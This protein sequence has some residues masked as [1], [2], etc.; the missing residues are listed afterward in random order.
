M[1][2]LHTKYW[3]LEKIRVEFFPHNN[4][5]C[6]SYVL[7]TLYSTELYSVLAVPN[8][9][10]EETTNLLSGNAFADSYENQCVHRE[11]PASAQK[12]KRSITYEETRLL[13]LKASK[14]RMEQKWD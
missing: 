13:N 4:T 9:H 7:T 5:V 6:C 10:E 14:K 1:Y 8:L 2:V 11:G 3:V 12:N